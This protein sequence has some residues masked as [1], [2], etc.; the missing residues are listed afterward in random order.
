M[1]R[2][3]SA[4][5][6]VSASCLGVAVFA[7]VLT[8]STGASAQNTGTLTG[9][10]YDQSGIPLRG[11]VVEATSPTQIGGIHTSVTND[12]GGFRLQGLYP[13]TFKLKLTAP[14]LR[15]LVQENVRVVAANIQEIDLIMEVETAS[16]EVQIIQK[17]PT[18]NLGS[19]KIGN[20]F[21]EEFMN[22]LPLATRDYQGVAALTPGVRDS[23]DG[24]PQ[25]RGGTYF[26]NSYT[27]DGFNTT[28][29]VTR[30]FGTNFSFN[31][32]SS[33]EVTTAGA[34]AENAGT[35][36]GTINIVTK[37]GSN[38]FEVDAQ[39]DYTDQNLQF[40]KDARD[41][42]GSNR[43]AVA[44]LFVGGPI[45]RDVLWYALSGEF[46]D[47]ESTL[48][49]DPA[50]GS[51]PTRKILG[52]NGT[53]KFTWRLSQR[54]Q[55][56]FRGQVSPGAFNNLIQSPLVEAEAEARQFQRTELAGLQWQ[57]VGD[58][59]LISRFAYQQ[60]EFDVGPQR[61]QWDPEHC[62]TI[63]AKI[64]LLS[65]IERENYTNQQIDQRRHFEFSGNAEWI[66][67][68][69]KFGNH[70]LRLTWD[71]EAAKNDVRSTITGDAIYNN[72]GTDPFSRSSACSND[73]SKA[74]GTC[75]QNFLRT[76]V[77]GAN[78]LVSLTESWKPT[79]YLTIRPGVAFHHGDSQTDRG[80]QVTGINAFS[81]HLAVLWDPTHD[82]K[83]KLQATFDGIVD[84]GFLA[85]A[86][87]TNRSLYRQNCSWD[88][89]LK[90]YS[91]N[92]R[93]EG[94]QDSTT[95]GLPCGPSGFRP[96]GTS[97]KTKLNPP[98]V[99]EATVAGEREVATGIVA[100]TT[101]VYRKFVHQWED[102][103][104]NANW[105]EGGTGLNRDAPFK[106]DRSQFIF[107]LETPDSASRVY[108]GATVELLKREGRLKA[109]LSYTL[110]KYEGSVDSDF[111]TVYL[112]NP[113]QAPYFYG[114]L[115]DDHRH[116]LRANAS[117]DV[118]TWLSTG[119][120]YNFLSGGPYNHVFFDPVYQSYT[121]FQAQRGYDS[122]GNTNPNDD[123]ELR[124]PDISSLDIQVR[125]SLERII[126]QKLSVWADVFNILALRT[127]LSYV[128]QDGP[129][130][131]Q[132]TSRM[133]ATRI[134]L[135]VQYRF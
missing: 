62:A 135:G 69:K 6:R 70:T 82:G 106:T 129:F 10:V 73:P 43:L 57:Y 84:T 1:I 125:A 72:L 2:S 126:H 94:G 7:F 123:F 121:R 47:N 13:G 53:A 65:G 102:L 67:D 134:R 11:V 21:D 91:R 24:N 37:S 87:F 115:A 103:E 128:T 93:A 19:T 55:L 113:P 116:D 122:R 118:L 35:S 54:N 22:S 96:D 17:A 131:G 30:T 58:I 107:D 110:S 39:A 85:L 109:Q 80:V 60:Q 95:V 36:G 92:C 42:T 23:G 90:S 45:R 114:P 50:L 3:F 34:G 49:L 26:S 8:V 119:V 71:Y 41:R 98:R 130:Y 63:P 4:A 89:E 66:K 15:T 46:V 12:E 27:V 32:M 75:S 51:H 5:C 68:T 77:V 117:Y 79:R 101:L 88:P 29:P 108:R 44:G 112:D 127:P 31:S 28:D 133:P 59:F 52:F 81:P 78:G 40:F 48:Q 99:W 86:S 61:C 132:T 9:H 83:T 56:E 64:D 18:V 111:A 97:C 105:N 76:S 120:T 100:R 20:T 124:Y 25:V 14:K 104:T 33:L 74:D 16:E 38:R